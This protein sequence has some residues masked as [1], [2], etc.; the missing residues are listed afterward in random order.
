VFIILSI[1]VEALSIV[2]IR[3]KAC[4]WQTSPWTGI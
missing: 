1:Q 3:V 2:C 4:N